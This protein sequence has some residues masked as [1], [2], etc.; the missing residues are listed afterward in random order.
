MCLSAGTLSAGTKQRARPNR[1]TVRKM[2]EE[3]RVREVEKSQS[4]SSADSCGSSGEGEGVSSCDGADVRRPSTSEDGESEVEDD[5]ERESGCGFLDGEAEEVWSCDES[6][7]EE[8]EWS[9]SGEEGEF[10]LDESREARHQL[11]LPE[12]ESEDSSHEQEEEEGE[13][14]NGG[15]FGS[16]SE[17]EGGSGGGCELPGHLRWKDGLAE[18]ARERFEQRQTS[19]RSLHKFIYCDPLP[20][21]PAE[22]AGEGEEGQEVGGLFHVAKRERRSELHS[23]DSSVVTR[24]LSRDWTTCV[25]AV[26]ST[27]FVT[28]SWG[29][30][31]AATLLQGDGEVGEFEDLETGERFGQE[32]EDEPQEEEE[33]RMKKKKEQKVF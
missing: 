7:E 29:E 16:D 31:D 13:S 8:I 14:E 33:E 24:Q 10:V 25:A 27:Q 28:G 5:R 20:T 15:D 2:R 9:E 11:R 22:A 12:L 17:S 19:S 3:E 6:S 32:A 4:L 23:E 21:T 26:K 18:K 30:E 1:N